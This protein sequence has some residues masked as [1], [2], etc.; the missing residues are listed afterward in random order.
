MLSERVRNPQLKLIVSFSAKLLSTK[1]GIGFVN[2]LPKGGTAPV[3]HPEYSKTS[4]SLANL[5]FFKQNVYLNFFEL[6]RWL[7]DATTSENG[8][9]QFF[10]PESLMIKALAPDFS[11]TPRIFAA[12]SDVIT[13]S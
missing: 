12:S 6:K 8:I 2:K 5:V 4:S 11:G 7:A 10:V 9:E 1:V 3:I 13:G